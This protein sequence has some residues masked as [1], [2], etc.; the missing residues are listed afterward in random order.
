[1]KKIFFGTIIIL[2]T[3]ILHAQ[4]VR[5]GIRGGMN[6]TSMSTVESTPLSEGYNSRIAAS[7]NIF[8][9]LQYNPRVAFRF[10]VEYSGLGGKKSGIQAVPTQ[11]LITEMGNSIGMGVTDDQLAALGALM[12]ALPPFYYA[13][14]DNIAKLQYVMIPVTA[15]FGWNIGQTSPWRFY[16]NAGPFVSFILAGKQLGKGTSNMYYD[17]TGTTTLWDALPM[18]IQ[19]FVAN[20]F[21]NIS[22]TLGDPVVFGETNTTGEMKS[23]NFGVT[24]NIGIRYKFNGNY[25]FM[26][27]GGNYGLLTVQD[28]DSNGS[29]RLGAV[30]VM[31]GYAISL[32]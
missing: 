26:E 1:M 29:N 18:P 32:F 4:D 16:V 2:T 12:M 22:K 23:A 15:Q 11:R 30:S 6:M 31:V 20:E 10:G 27:V 21:P 19:G 9:E 17:A 28:D 25:L 13:N 5:F 24:G 8:T 3:C 7:W 14:V